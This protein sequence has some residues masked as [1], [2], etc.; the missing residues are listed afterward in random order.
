MGQRKSQNSLWTLGPTV[1]FP[2]APTPFLLGSLDIHFTSVRFL[3]GLSL[4]SVAEMSV[5]KPF[6]GLLFPFMA[7]C[8]FLCDPAQKN[9]FPFSHSSPYGRA[10][11]AFLFSPR[12][13]AVIGCTVLTGQRP[14]GRE[15][16]AGLPHSWAWQLRRAGEQG[17][18][19]QPGSPCVHSCR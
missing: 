5:R 17:Q 11:P 19:P 9:P 10:R 12:L 1:L 15:D 2:P 4:F 13:T 7:T 14:R 16:G 3:W 6:I 18:A 8:P